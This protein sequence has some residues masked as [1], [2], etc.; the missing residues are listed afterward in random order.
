MSYCRF[1]EADVYVYMDFDGYLACCGCIL[2]DTWHFHSTGDMVAHLQEH[3]TAGHQVPA[4][5]IPALEADDAE[6]FPAVEGGG[7]P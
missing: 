3:V 5:V 6:N 4:W 1:G 7:S 2:G